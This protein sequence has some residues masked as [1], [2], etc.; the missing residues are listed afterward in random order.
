MRGE[1]PLTQQMDVYA[2]GICCGEILTKGE[3]P[4]PTMDNDAVRH[5]VL[6]EHPLWPLPAL[7]HYDGDT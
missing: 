4:W 7:S 5:F 1:R 6:S 2:F 3:L